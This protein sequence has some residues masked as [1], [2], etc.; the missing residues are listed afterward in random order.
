MVNIQ[1]GRSIEEIKKMNKEKGIYELLDEMG[2]DWWLM[3]K[4]DPSDEDIRL[5]KEFY[6]Y[7][8]EHELLPY[9]VSWQEFK[10]CYARANAHWI[11][12][13][14]LDEDGNEITQTV[15]LDINSKI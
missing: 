7:W 2:Y 14:G 3:D 4:D 9:Q 15:L 6:R 8:E 12:D 5:A 13:M 10:R 11:E 1:S